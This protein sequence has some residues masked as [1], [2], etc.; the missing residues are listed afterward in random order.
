MSILLAAFG[1]MG[2]PADVTPNAVNWADISSATSPAANA[3]QTID[4]CSTSITISITNSGSGIV[5]YRLDSG[6][7]VT[8][9]VP[10]SVDALTGQTL[11]WQVSAVA[12]QVTG[13]I[14]VINDSDSSTTLDTFTYDVTDPI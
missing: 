8:Y 4:G 3:N 7:Y 12:G 6:S 11:N 13:T 10:F 9:T 2:A 1:A 14:T 5:E